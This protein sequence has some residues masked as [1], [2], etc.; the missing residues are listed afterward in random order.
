MP[1]TYALPFFRPK[2]SALAFWL[3]A[4]AIYGGIALY[5]FGDP[6]SHSFSRE[7]LWQYIAAIGALAD[8][9]WSPLNP[10]VAGDFA[11]RL[12]GPVHLATGIV[13]HYLH[14]NLVQMFGLVC[15]FNAALL[16]AGIHVFAL[17]YYRSDWGPAA[18][19]AVLICGWNIQPLVFTGIESPAAL[20]FGIGYPAT[21]AI[22]AGLLAWGWSIALLETRDRTPW[23]GLGGIALLVAAMFINHQLGG[24]IAII[25][26]ACL[27]AFWPALFRRRVALAAAVAAGLALAALWPWFDVYAVFFTANRGFWNVPDFNFYSFAVLFTMLAPGIIGIFALRLPML[28]MLAC[29]FGIYMLG[30]VGQPVAHRFLAPTALVLHIGYAQLV[31]DNWRRRSGL[32]LVFTI[33]LFAI[34]SWATYSFIGDY[35]VIRSI[36][37]NVMV[38]ARCLLADRPTGIAAYEVAAWPIVVNGLKVYVTPYPET[39]I[40]DQEARWQRNRALFEAPV[41]AAARRRMAAAIGVRVLVAH[42]IGD[43][44]ALSRPDQARLARQAWRVS[45]I[46]SLVRYDLFP[47]PAGTSPAV[48]PADPGCAVTRGAAVAVAPTGAR[49]AGR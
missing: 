7:D 1:S 14:L 22:G 6:V 19:L 26:M 2:T 25:G 34:N 42:T 48:V 27:G 40:P 37:G 49:P 38:N 20:I 21:T 24:G 11:S 5:W 4:I 29:F 28:A 32:I 8:D 41:D 46:Q 43:K 47:P 3:P 17:K 9:P 44:L 36:N 18:L 13:G 12:F 15:L 33:P 35:A 45:H 16:V 31:F 10:F 30:L 39:L 23:R